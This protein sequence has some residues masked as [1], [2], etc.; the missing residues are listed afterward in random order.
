M[1][2]FDAFCNSRTTKVYS[3]SPHSEPFHRCGPRCQ[4]V[5][6]LQLRLG[7]HQKVEEP[8]ILTECKVCVGAQVRPSRSVVCCFFLWGGVLFLGPFVN[9]WWKKGPTFCRCGLNLHPQSPSPRPKAAVKLPI[10]GQ[11][12]H[13]SSWKRVLIWALQTTGRP[14]EDQQI[15]K[16]LNFRLKA[17]ICSKAGCYNFM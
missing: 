17:G 12:K 15:L 7:Q 11:S 16:H 5:H 2:F 13:R 8:A 10:C 14:L 3:V 9:E 6:A 4:P 1:F